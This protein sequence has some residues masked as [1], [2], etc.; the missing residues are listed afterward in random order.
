MKNAHGSQLFGALLI[1]A[2]LCWFEI[3]IAYQWLMLELPTSGV[4]PLFIFGLT[5]VGAVFGFIVASVANIA[6]RLG[7][8]KLRVPLSA[9]A[10][11]AFITLTAWALLSAGADLQ[12]TLVA[13]A[14][15]AVCGL[16]IGPYHAE[17][18][19]GLWFLERLQRRQSSSS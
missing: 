14:I 13:A 10:W 2:V 15:T 4:I 12:R 7:P 17:L 5:V 8:P 9:I 3:V 19:V 11:L 1:V 16:L 18:L 6:L